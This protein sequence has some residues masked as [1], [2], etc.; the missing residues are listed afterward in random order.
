MPKAAYI[1]PCAAG[2]ER[3]WL[4]FLLL[5]C[6]VVAAGLSAV[7]AWPGATAPGGKYGEPLKFEPP[8][9]DLDFESQGAKNP[10]P[11]PVVEDAPAPTVRTAPAQKPS[12]AQK[13]AQAQT[14]VQ[15]AG[16]PAQDEGQ[17]GS[18][19]EGART[20]RLFGT[21]EFRSALKNLPKWDRVLNAERQ[22]PTF[23]ADTSRM[24]ENVAAQWKKQSADLAGKPIME[25]I[26]KV[27]NFFNQWPYKTDAAVWGVEDYWATPAEFMKKSGDCEDYAISK[28][29]A[30]RSLGVPADR[31]RIVVL[32]DSIR[33]LGHAVLVVYVDDKAYILDNLTNLVLSHQRLTHY[34][35]QY[36]VNEEFLWRH[37]RPVNKQT[38]APGR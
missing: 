3:A 32:I 38:K 29:Y 19:G 21:V 7:V 17:A 22:R 9:V 13:T 2:M 4:R 12:P 36:S 34:V 27:N 20:T 37:I 24:P 10:T 31:L 1:Q 18:A 30:L 33:Q 6:V 14:A 23:G 5:L 11:E 26:Q 35:P 25:Q 15:T 8:P 16:D 28:Y